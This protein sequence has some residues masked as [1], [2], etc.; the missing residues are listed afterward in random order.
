MSTDS[1][2]EEKLTGV[3]S[4]LYAITQNV[5]NGFSR[6]VAGPCVGDVP[7]KNIVEALE[8]Q[9]VE[10]DRKKSF[11]RAF[12]GNKRDERNYPLTSRIDKWRVIRYELGNNNLDVRIIPYE[13][14]EGDDS[15]KLKGSGAVY[16]NGVV[17]A[18]R[19]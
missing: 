5:P 16:K 11:V 1:K 9:G 6:E 2:E 4:L 15:P 17:C 14:K 13:S 3:Y 10:I 12:S 19:F 8:K 18:I 7:L